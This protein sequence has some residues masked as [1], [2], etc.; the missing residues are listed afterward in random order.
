MVKKIIIFSS[1]IFLV[2]L[3]F[4]GYYGGRILFTK[5]PHF[6]N[7][8][9][10]NSPDEYFCLKDKKKNEIIQWLQGMPYENSL[11]GSLSESS[12]TFDEWLNKGEQLEDIESSLLW[13]YK[14]KFKC[15]LKESLSETLK[16]YGTEKS[17]DF[18]SDRLYKHK[19]AKETEVEIYDILYGII[20][21]QKEFH[22]LLEKIEREKDKLSDQFNPNEAIFMK[23]PNEFEPNEIDLK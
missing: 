6:P 15:L 17:V 2:V 13:L 1:A 10:I 23:S 7:G 20:K 16:Q 4:L 9:Y 3:T 18:F 21:D 22:Q 8:W 19:L 11:M 5:P 14:S 12:Y